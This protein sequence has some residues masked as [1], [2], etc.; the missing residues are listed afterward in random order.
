MQNNLNQILLGQ[1]VMKTGLQLSK[2][3]L[4]EI[5]ISDPTLF[6]I[7][8]NMETQNLNILNKYEIVKETLYLTTEV[9]GQQVYRLCLPNF[10]GQE[11]LQKLHFLNDS[12]L[13]PD[14]LL[15]MFNTNFYTAGAGKIV[16]TILQKCILCR[17]N[18]N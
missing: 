11:V 12:H 1:Y 13:T 5:Q 7:I 9:Y 8:S 14:N 6:K 2:D 4:R 10:L 3:D 15:R 16:K 18:K 17:L